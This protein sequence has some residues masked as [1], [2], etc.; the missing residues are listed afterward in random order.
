MLQDRLIYIATNNSLFQVVLI[1]KSLGKLKK[2]EENKLATFVLII[3]YLRYPPLFYDPAT[4]ESL[5]RIDKDIARAVMSTQQWDKDIARGVM[6][7]QQCISLKATK[8]RIQCLMLFINLDLEEGD[9]QQL[10]KK[11]TRSLM[12]ASLL[13]MAC[14]LGL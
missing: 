4:I 5:R 7:T 14:C 12:Q 8:R 1:N 2:K 11:M 10:K 3:F 6:L 13:L 9:E